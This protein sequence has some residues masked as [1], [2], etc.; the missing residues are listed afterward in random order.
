MTGRRV[1]TRRQSSRLGE[2]TGSTVSVESFGGCGAGC[3][4]Q[5]RGILPLLGGKLGIVW[6]LKQRGQSPTRSCGKIE[7]SCSFSVAIAVP[8]W[9]VAGSRHVGSG[10]APARKGGGIRSRRHI[11]LRI[12]PPSIMLGHWR[13]DKGGNVAI[14]LGLIVLMLVGIMLRRGCTVIVHVGRW[15]RWNMTVVDSSS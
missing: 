10:A 5:N 13:R 9:I 7:R 15:I 6:S 8:G 4:P 1:R 3:S 2:R 12:V 14:V 11:D